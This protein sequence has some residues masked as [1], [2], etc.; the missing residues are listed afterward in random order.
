M[1]GIRL[2]LGIWNTTIPNYA[3]I[4]S[5][6]F[7][8]RDGGAGH[9]FTGSCDGLNDGLWCQSA[10]NVSDI[11]SWQLPN[12][13]AVPD[14][15]DA[16]PIHMA[17]AYGQVGLLRSLGISYSPY[18][19]MYTCTIPDENGTTQTLV[20]WAAGNVAYNGTGG[21]CELLCLSLFCQ[22]GLIK[23]R[24]VKSISHLCI[25]MQPR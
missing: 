8:E 18:Q 19:G 12:G 24:R 3:M 6:D 4:A 21:N 11:G 2:Y 25:L 16:E 17:N 1:L 13:T 14:D 7:G 23:S 5:R 20:V 22:C 10:N 15:L 9:Q